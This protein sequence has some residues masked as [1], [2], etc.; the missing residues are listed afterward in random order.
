MVCIDE[1]IT[2]LMLAYGFFA[3]RRRCLLSRGE[4]RP[5]RV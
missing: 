1:I 4:R 2:D 3:E 5:V